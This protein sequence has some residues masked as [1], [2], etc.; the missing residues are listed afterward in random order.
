MSLF[1]QA[2][3]QQTQNT[4]DTIDLWKKCFREDSDPHSFRYGRHGL[5]GKYCERII[6]QHCYLTTQRTVQ[7]HL[8]LI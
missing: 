1:L 3:K 8:V 7:A 4:N 2:L 6:V 5:L